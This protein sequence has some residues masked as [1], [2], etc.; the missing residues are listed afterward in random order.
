MR[1]ANSKA[2]Q[3]CR[4]F[5]FVFLAAN[6]DRICSVCLRNRMKTRFLLRLFNP[7]NFVS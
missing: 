3:S 1:Y 7:A 5:S 4:Q 2:R 6:L